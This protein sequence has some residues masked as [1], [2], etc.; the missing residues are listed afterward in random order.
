MK[1]VNHDKVEFKSVWN[2]YNI[3][4]SSNKLNFFVIFFSL[5]FCTYIKM[6]KDSAAK[7]YKNNKQGLQKK[8]C[9]I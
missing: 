3:S 4:R 9:E 6:S 7:Y 1:Y 5:L 2:S 8:A